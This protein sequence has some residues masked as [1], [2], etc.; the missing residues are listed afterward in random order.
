MSIYVHKQ[1]KVVSPM[2]VYFQEIHLMVSKL[3]IVG[4]MLWAGEVVLV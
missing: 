1:R 3:G 4:V 2:K